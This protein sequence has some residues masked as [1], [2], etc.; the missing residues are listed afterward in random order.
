MSLS[1]VHIITTIDLGGAEKQLA[2]LATKQQQMGYFVKIIFLKG[3]PALLN[4]FLASGIEVD[5]K[6]SKMS[7]FRQAIMLRDQAQYRE[8]V[9]HAHLPRAELLC[10]LALKSKSFL[11]T[12]H[13]SEQFFPKAPRFISRLLSRFV[14]RKASHV[15]SISVAVSDYLYSSKELTSSSNNHVIY[16][17][18]SNTDVTLINKSKLGTFQIGT[19][20]RLVP[21][22]NLPLLLNTARVLCDN[23]SS[24]FQI[25]IVGVGP[26][27][28]ELKLLSS[29][30]GIT[31]FLTWKGQISNPGD[32]YQFLDVF[33]LPSNYEGFGLVLLEAMSHGIPIVARRISAIPEVL[34]KGHPG[35]LNSNNPEDLAKMIWRILI[36]ENLR[37]DILHYQFER[38]RYFSIDKT[39]EKHAEL[40][41]DFSRQKGR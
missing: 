1:V 38:L 36:E 24:N 28:G 29:H 21:Q 13:N 4:H 2:I 32:Y 23:Y 5:L 30:L 22:K 27:L 31:E 20:C 15:I 18:L 34:G 3:D 26:E 25:S 37:R 17:G 19:V 39:Y 8:T 33:V 14:L 7:F 12:R 35:L 9:Y 40:Y 41:M 16:Y 10:A 6:F 11:V